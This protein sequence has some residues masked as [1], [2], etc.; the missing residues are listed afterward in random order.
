VP[1]VLCN[2]SVGVQTESEACVGL[3]IQ[4]GEGNVRLSPGGM[5]FA[6]VRI[7]LGPTGTAVGGV[8]HVTVII[9]ILKI[10]DMLE[11]E[12]DLFIVGQ[13]Q[14]RG[15]QRNVPGAAIVGA[16]TVRPRMGVA[17]GVLRGDGP[18]PLGGPSL[19]A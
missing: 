8:F 19:V 6:V 13:I 10:I 4:R 9:T 14:N 18:I 16:G 2:G 12:G 11:A 7:G 17:A 5:V 15:N 1:A 3:A